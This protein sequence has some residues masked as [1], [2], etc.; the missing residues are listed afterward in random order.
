[1]G[2]RIGVVAF[3]GGEGLQRGDFT[4]HLGVDLYVSSLPL[5]KLKIYKGLVVGRDVQVFQRNNIRE[6]KAHNRA[7]RR[8]ILFYLP[9][10]RIKQNAYIALNGRI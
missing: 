4:S 7:S 9:I 6:E 8:F 3:F 1:M 2:A 10:S 5:Y